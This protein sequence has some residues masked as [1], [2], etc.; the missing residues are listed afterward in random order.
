MFST[1]TKQLIEQYN[2]TK[3]SKQAFMSLGFVEQLKEV[4]PDLTPE[5]IAEIVKWKDGGRFSEDV[6]INYAQ[7]FISGLGL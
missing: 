2:E 4:N 1:D 3:E 6:L 7:D 5:Q